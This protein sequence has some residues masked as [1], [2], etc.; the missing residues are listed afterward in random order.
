MALSSK[1]VKDV[2]CLSCGHLQ[3]KYL[4]EEVDA[5]YKVVYLCR[6]KSP[7]KKIIDDEVSVYLA[8]CKWNGDDPDS[9]GVPLGDNCP[10]YVVLK[11][12]LQGYDVKP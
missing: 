7:D 11:T 2:C 10:G 6:K 3:C 12:K 1:Q 9:Q 5:N 4:D 8:D